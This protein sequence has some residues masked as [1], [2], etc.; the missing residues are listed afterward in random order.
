MI[1]SSGPVGAEPCAGGVVGA[2]DVPW[3][4]AEVIGL[5]AGAAQVRRDLLAGLESEGVGRV[6]V[7]HARAARV[8]AEI[9]AKGLVDGKSAAAGQDA[10]GDVDVHLR[11]VAGHAGRVP[12]ILAE[13]VGGI[14]RDC[15]MV[16]PAGAELVPG[17]RLGHASGAARGDAVAGCDSA[18]HGARVCVRG[19]GGVSVAVLGRGCVANEV[20]CGRV[21]GGGRGHVC[22][23]A[24]G[25]NTMYVGPAHK[26]CHTMYGALHGPTGQEVTHGDQHEAPADRRAEPSGP[27][28]GAQGQS[29]RQARERE[30]EGVHGAQA[31]PLGRGSAQARVTR[32]RGALA[33][34]DA[35]MCAPRN[36][37]GDG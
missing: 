21:G 19:E 14:R 28:Q 30:R 9:G 18:A 4:P 2:A 3:E 1:G 17:P 8:V 35:A 7:T 26:P 27:R 16:S 34:D 12:A 29:A 37:D 13:R 10:G 25:R 32:E 33:G 6:G 11:L 24:P 15:E 31:Q 23:P 22:S 20:E 36:V 5:V